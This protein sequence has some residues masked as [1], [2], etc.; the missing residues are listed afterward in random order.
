MI[1]NL[2]LL[3]FLGF[4]G[5]KSG[6]AVATPVEKVGPDLVE[7]TMER[8]KNGRVEPMAT[9]HVFQTGDVIRMRLNS[10][11]LGYLY[12]MNQ[13]T[14]G[15]FST[16]FPAPDTGNDNRVL[17][18]KQY[19]VPAVEEGWFEV[20]GPARL[21]YA[22]FPAESDCAGRAKRRILCGARTRQFTQ[23]PLQ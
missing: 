3:L 14:S 18:D 23:A 19:L 4:P 1:S 6:N 15:R 8:K 2:L 22:L 7:I 17:P 11:Y 5:M 16:V 9:G 21:R 13:G 12:V 10:H 20:Q